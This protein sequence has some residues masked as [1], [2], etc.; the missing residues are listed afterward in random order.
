MLKQIFSVTAMNL[1]SLPLRLGASLVTV[2]GIGCVVGVMVSLLAINAGLDQT[3]NKGSRPDEAIVLSAGATAAYMG[4]IS[5]Q[6]AA[7]VADAPGIKKGPDGKPLVDP[8]AT[9]V[10]EV[11]KL[12]DGG[13]ANTGLQGVA[14]QWLQNDPHFKLVKGRMFRPGLRE[15]IVGKQARTQFKNMD[16]GDHLSVRGSDWTVVGA[17]DTNGGLADNAIIGDTDTVL[18]AFDRNAFQSISIRLD[19]PGSFQRTKD[20]LTSNPQIKVDV[21]KQSQYVQD[22]LQQLTVILNFVGYFVGAVMA[23]GAVFGALNT[24]YSAVDS[25]TREIATLRALGFGGLSVMVSV[26]VEA[27]LLALLGALLGALVAWLL[28]N[29][30]AAHISS[31]TFPLIVTPGLVVLGV[32]WSLIIGLI[33]GFAPSIRAARIP[34]VAALRAT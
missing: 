1:S 10:V 19:S 21:K 11:T 15:V 29:G 32:I 6:E 23:V 22:Q 13:T 4:S 8:E 24:M 28:F 3:A 27:L 17:F 26:M 12:S 9:I 30:N 25:R 33:G 2:I 14:A 18:A 5:R 20:W 16:V 31:L 34:V 7:I